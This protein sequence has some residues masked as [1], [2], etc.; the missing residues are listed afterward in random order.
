MIVCKSCGESQTLT[1]TEPADATQP[2]AESLNAEPVDDHSKER[3][4]L[5]PVIE[6]LEDEKARP[7]HLLKQTIDTL[8][9][10]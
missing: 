3:S 1:L 2:G 8:E 6:G 4:I 10:S 9:K 7:Q 5:S